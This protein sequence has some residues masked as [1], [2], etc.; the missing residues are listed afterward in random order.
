[1]PTLARR[2]FENAIHPDRHG[3]KLAEAGAQNRTTVQL[4][5]RIIIAVGSTHPPLRC[6]ARWTSSSCCALEMGVAGPSWRQNPEHLPIPSSTREPSAPLRR[7]FLLF[8]RLE[9]PRR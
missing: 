8:G 3:A 2:E 5:E 7:G 4:Q 9:H 1:M 6:A